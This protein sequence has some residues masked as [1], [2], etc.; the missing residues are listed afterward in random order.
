MSEKH[1][2]VMVAGATGYIGGGVLQVLH[3]RGFWVRALCRDSSRL[4]NP[5]WCDEVFVGQA[6]QPET[7]KG[8]C[9]GIDVAFSSIGTR[10]FKRRPNIWEVDYQANL[11]LLAVDQNAG[12]RHF[13]FVSVIRGSKWLG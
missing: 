1:P 6:T 10:S 11:N 8:L 4:R 7:L 9:E 12:V 5:N 3:Q 2:R 13:I